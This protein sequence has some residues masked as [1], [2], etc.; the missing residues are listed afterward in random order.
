[1]P[2]SEILLRTGTRAGIRLL[3]LLLFRGGSVLHGKRS[4][5]PETKFR[6]APASLN[7]KLA[8]HVRH[9]ADGWGRLRTFER[10]NVGARD[11]FVFTGL[12]VEAVVC[13]CVW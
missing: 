9:A 8:S 2:G 4:K 5:Y 10:A 11:A 6:V 12:M 3:L 13:V 7:T 1:M